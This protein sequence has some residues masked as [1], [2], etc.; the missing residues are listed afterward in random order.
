MSST[1]ENRSEGFHA[2]ALWLIIYVAASFASIVALVATGRSGAENPP[3]WALA[4][5]VA[6]MWSVYLYFFP[7]F[8]PF[9]DGSLRRQFRTWFS[10]RDLWI[11]IPLGIG[12]Q[13]ILMNLV[14]WPLSQL[15][16]DQFSPEKISERADEIASTAPGWWAL[17]LVA[18]VVVGA[19][20][21]EEIV[22]RGCLQTRMVKAFGRNVGIVSTAA[23][24]ALIHLSPVEIPGLFVFA[25]VLGVVRHWTGTLGLAIV[26]HLAFNATGLSL[27]MLL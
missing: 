13:L 6:A 20:I 25:L 11:G 12:S 24:F 21:V 1:A 9:S 8:L 5:N 10:L 19:P 27:V 26:T 17:L 22:Y 2:L 7:R 4:V 3:M 18:V 15:F 14:N 16:P 23:L